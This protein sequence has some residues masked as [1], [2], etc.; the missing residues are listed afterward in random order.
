MLGLHSIIKQ[1]DLSRLWS[2]RLKGVIS[3]DWKKWWK[4]FFPLHIQLS[5]RPSD[6]QELSDLLVSDASMATFKD[7]VAYDAAD[8]SINT[9]DLDYAFDD[10]NLLEQVQYLITSGGRWHI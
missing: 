6:Y 3:V 2:T 9:Y 1:E 4:H 8:N 5:E 10:E 7:A